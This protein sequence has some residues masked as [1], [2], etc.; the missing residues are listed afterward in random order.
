MKPRDTFLKGGNFKKSNL[1]EA[2]SNATKKA[3]GDKNWDRV[4]GND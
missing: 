3:K 2:T 4:N 1:D